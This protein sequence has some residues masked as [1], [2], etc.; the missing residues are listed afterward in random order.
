MVDV[1][2]ETAAEELSFQNALA[3]KTVGAMTI[4]FY[5]GEVVINSNAPLFRRRRLFKDYLID[6][7]K[8]IGINC[9]LHF[10]FISGFQ[11]GQAIQQ[12]DHEFHNSGAISCVEIIDYRDRVEKFYGANCQL[13]SGHMITYEEKKRILVPSNVRSSDNNGGNL[14]V[15]L[16]GITIV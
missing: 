4:F 3:C 16:D 9:A 7:A 5:R 1:T 12:F 11:K 10:E 2:M 14:R 13:L 8:T 6:S 15:L